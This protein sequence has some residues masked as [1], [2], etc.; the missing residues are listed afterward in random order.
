[1]LKKRIKELEKSNEVL[2]SLFEETKVNINNLE[3]KVEEEAKTK[4]EIINILEEKVRVQ[5]EETKV[6][7]TN[8]EEKV[9]ELEVISK[10]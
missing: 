8:L 3:E 5:E 10:K 9:K 1:D 2:R 7:I 4:Q 6:N